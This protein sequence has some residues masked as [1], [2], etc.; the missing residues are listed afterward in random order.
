LDGSIDIIQDNAGDDW[1]ATGFE[2]ATSTLYGVSVFLGLGSLNITSGVE[3][4]ITFGY[5]EDIFS[6]EFDNVNGI[7]Y[8]VGAPP[9]TTVDPVNQQLYKINTSTGDLTVVGNLNLFTNSSSYFGLDEG[10]NGLAYDPAANVLYGVSYSGN[11][12]RINVNDASSTL[13]G[14]TAP[15]CR[16]LAYD[17]GSQKLWG[18][19]NNA[20]LIE[21]DKNTGAQLSS[22]PCQENFNFITSLAYAPEPFEIQEF[23]CT[24]TVHVLLS[25]DSFLSLGNDTL[26]CNTPEFTL[27][28]PGFS[29]YLWQDG[30]EDDQI[31][32]SASGEYILQASNSAGC[33]DTDTLSI[34]F[35]NFS[36]TAVANP[37]NILVGDTVQLNASG[38][39]SY[40]W[41]PEEGLSC[42]NCASPFATPSEST[43]YIV[44]AI[45]SNGCRSSDT[46]RVEVD[47]R[48]KEPFIPTIFSPNGKGPQTNETFCVLSDCVE[49]FKLVIHNRWGE[50]VFETEDITQCWDGIFKENEA[51][52]GVYAFNLYLRQLDGTVVNKTGTIT[53]VR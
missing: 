10:I 19:K 40:L 46:L 17:A 27:S 37:T 36:V 4:P 51:A 7:F 53:L 14:S 42:S 5:P 43:T 32:A 18:I 52:S 12:Y 35:V 11:L 48:C 3:V 41:N 45:D 33:I 28:Q 23:T 9:Q 31:I 6:G 15:D 47:I 39:F 50:R 34:Q 21:I 29:N 16:G 1:I 8:A 20:T 38:A 25:S 2:S 13:V 44:S 26:L 24:D 49:Q 30:S 22:V